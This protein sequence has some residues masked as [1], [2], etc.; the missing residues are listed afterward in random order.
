MTDKLATYQALDAIYRRIPEIA[1]QRK[2]QEACG[3][4]LMSAAEWQRIKEHGPVPRMVGMSCPILVNNNSACGR[5][6][7]R[8]A[9]CRL[10]GAVKRMRC[11]WGCKPK[12]WLSD[13]EAG[14]I[15]VAVQRLSNHEIAGPARD[16][17]PIKL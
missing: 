15:L 3:P 17:V 5:Y 13:D 14:E 16:L 2:C 10:W 8:P 1:C 6:T 4:I 7:L 12:R 9:I 11:P